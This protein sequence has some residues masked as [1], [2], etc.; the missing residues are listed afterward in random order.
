MKERKRFTSTAKWRDCWFQR[1][2]PATKLIFL[3]LVDTCDAAGV[4]EPNF[5]VAEAEMG[6][7]GAGVNIGWHEVFK[8]LNQPAEYP[9]PGDRQGREIRPAVPVQRVMLTQTRQWWVRDFCQFQ[10]G[11]LRENQPGHVPA[12]RSLARHDLLA[13]YAEIF[14]EG[15][16][17]GARGGA[18]Q[19]FP[20]PKSRR[21]PALE[22]MRQ[23]PEAQGMPETELQVFYHHYAALRWR[24]PNGRLYADFRAI[25]AKW[26]IAGEDRTPA[27]L[28]AA[29]VCAL[30]ARIADLDGRLHELSM[31]TFKPHPAAEPQ[32]R[33]KSLEEMARL[34]NEKASLQTLL[35]HGQSH[36][37]N[38]QV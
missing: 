33:P 1:L 25:L 15:I 35:A 2:R 30:K 17:E 36:H 26:R 4:W 8:E 22:D 32:I 16:A 10:Y 3:Y 14:P 38:H 9:W 28:S 7:A 27:E 23:W 18:P 31:D 29:T 20:F 21:L 6:F 24:Q 19:K 37:P 11:K 12:L 34:E 5:A 13:T